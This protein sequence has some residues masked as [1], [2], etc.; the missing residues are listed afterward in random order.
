MTDLSERAVRHARLRSLAQAQLTADGLVL[1]HAGPTEALRVLF[2]LASS[3]ATASTA[4]ALL[5][6]LQVQQAEVDVQDEELRQSRFALETALG[7]QRELYDWA[8]LA[9]L[10][11]DQQGRICELNQRAALLLE[12]AREA[13]IGRL[14][15]I[16]LVPESLPVLSALFA[17]LA[18]GSST[19]VSDLELRHGS[20]RYTLARASCCVDPAGGGY[21]LGLLTDA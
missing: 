19:A 4:L 15:G 3:P 12:G 2:D 16:Y 9:Y 6:E 7:R 5:Q 8:P 10:T 21:L 14:L 20:G 17:R 18:T 1:P 11:I 13:L